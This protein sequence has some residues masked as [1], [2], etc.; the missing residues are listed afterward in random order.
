MIWQRAF[1]DYEQS[2]FKGPGGLLVNGDAL[3][4]SFDIYYG[5]IQCIYLDPPSISDKSPVLRMPIGKKGWEMGGFYLDQP[6]YENYKINSQENYAGF[7]RSILKL[8]YKL[9]SDSGSL[10]FHIDNGF[11]YQA[12]QIVDEVFGTDNFVNEIIWYYKSGGSAKRFFGRRHETILYYSKNFKKRYFNI[13]SV[14]SGK[15]RDSKNHLK[16]HTDFTGKSYRTLKSG[17]KKYIYYDDAPTY[18]SDVWDDISQITAR[19]REY[20]G[21]ESQ[22]PEALIERIILSTTKE[23]DYFADLMCGSGSSLVAASNN[24]RQ[25]IGADISPHAISV[26]R[27]RLYEHRVKVLAPLM[28]DSA[29]LDASVLPGIGF[30][31][32]SLNSYTVSADDTMRITDAYGNI[33]LAPLDLVDQWY[34]GLIRN[35]VF[36]SFAASVRTKEEPRLLRKLQVPLLKGEVAIM[37][38]DIFGRRSLW[39][40][41]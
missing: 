26:S 6:A 7:L 31:D 36:Y 20:T 30:Y 9:L 13:S 33:S 32:V 4:L 8:S 10:F 2:N 41:S 19:S 1:C 25:F 28:Q 35:K 21:F 16:R 27:K 40:S 5:K 18:P 24:K 29:M 23:G 39:K 22:K 11:S 14:P 37:V 38:I 17:E 12:R 3:S 34:A 15:K